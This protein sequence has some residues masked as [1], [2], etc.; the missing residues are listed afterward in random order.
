MRHWKL[1]D[2]MNGR[3]L[4]YSLPWMNIFFSFLYLKQCFLPGSEAEVLNLQ[5]VAYIP[6]MFL[7]WFCSAFFWNLFTNEKGISKIFPTV[8]IIA[9]LLVPVGILFV[10]KDIYFSLPILLAVLEPLKNKYLYK[11]VET[12]ID[13]TKIFLLI[14]SFILLFLAALLSS[15]IGLK[16]EEYL[17]GFVYYLFLFFFDY[18]WITYFQSDKE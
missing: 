9:L 11:S 7:L 1:S 12:K 2:S 6:F 10:S 4:Q 13:S 15:L 17:F 3:L 8:F 14:A 18:K 5:L 16:H